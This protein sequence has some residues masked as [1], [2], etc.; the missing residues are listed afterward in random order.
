[1]AQSFNCLCQSTSCRG[2]ISGAGQMPR[3]QLE[4]LWLS[5][6]IRDMLEEKYGGPF[7]TSTSLLSEH[8]C[9]STTSASTAAAVAVASR[10]GSKGNS[11]TADVKRGEDIVIKALQDALAQAERG[12]DAARIALLSYVGVRNGPTSRELSGE[13]GGDTETVV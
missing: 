9:S 11:M 2:S 12:V 4:G 1:M 10:V 5:G 7:S 8:P 3:S 6:H 13:M